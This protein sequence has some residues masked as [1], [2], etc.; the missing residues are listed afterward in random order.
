M[1]L[2]LYVDDI[3]VIGNHPSFIATVI[4]SLRQNFDLKDFGRLHYFLG[5]HIEYTPSVLFVCQ[6]KYTL[7]L[8]HQIFMFDCKPCKT[9]CTLAAYL[10]ANDSSLLVDPTFYRSMVGAL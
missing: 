3:I 10:V 5:L 1:F 6:T 8:F 9:P 7:D 4:G 2:L